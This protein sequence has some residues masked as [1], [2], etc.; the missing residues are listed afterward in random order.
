MD[1][2]IVDQN[3]FFLSVS[4][5]D[6]IQGKIKVLQN[7]I[8]QSDMSSLFKK[9]LIYQFLTFS[10]AFIKNVIFPPF[11]LVAVFLLNSS[12]VR[13]N[14]SL[15]V[16]Y[17]LCIFQ[18]GEELDLLNPRS[19]ALFLHLLPLNT[20]IFLGEESK[21]EK[22]ISTPFE[23]IICFIYNKDAFIVLFFYHDDIDMIC[24]CRITGEYT[25]PKT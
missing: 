18:G 16:F 3:K 11:F 22:T 4:I 17:I 10:C 9:A 24:W 23:H 21:E 1:V 5:N 14:T 7:I 15:Y 25:D 6:Y 20:S 12:L 13:E 2:Y 8:F 19:Q